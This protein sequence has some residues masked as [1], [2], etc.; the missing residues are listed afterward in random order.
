[1]PA[2]GT[3]ILPRFDVSAGFNIV[4]GKKPSSEV[5][6]V[7]ILSSLIYE[8]GSNPAAPAANTSQEMDSSFLSMVQ[9]IEDDSY[10]CPIG[11]LRDG[12]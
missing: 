6:A 9:E 8:L 4:W 5:I 11:G 10:L 1:M 3:S 2:R 7:S 12:A